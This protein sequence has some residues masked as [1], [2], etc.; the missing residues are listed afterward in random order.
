MAPCGSLAFSAWQEAH[1]GVGFPACGS[2][3]ETQRW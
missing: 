1:A 3:H 2:W